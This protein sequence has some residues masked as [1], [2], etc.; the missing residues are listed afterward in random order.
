MIPASRASSS[1][2]PSAP[3]PLLEGA[4]APHL[5]LHP[6]RSLRAVSCQRATWKRCR[7]RRRPWALTWL[8]RR[9]RLTSRSKWCVGGG[10]RRVICSWCVCAPVLG[11]RHPVGLDQQMHALLLLWPALRS[12]LIRCSARLLTPHPV[13]VIHDPTPT[14]RPCPP[15]SPAA[16]A[17]HVPVRLALRFRAHLSAAARRGGPAAGAGPAHDDD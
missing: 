7:R 4:F 5:H 14:C 12:G 3:G 13:L 17:R 2:T 6:G 10:L 9:Q 15:T 1:R 8:R 16:L 11:S